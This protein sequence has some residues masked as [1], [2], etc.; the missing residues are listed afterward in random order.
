ME[1]YGVKISQIVNC[2]GIADK[3]ALVMQIYADVHGR[4]MKISRSGA[5][6]RAR[7]GHRGGPS[8]RVRT[9]I[10]ASGA[11]ENDRSETRLFTSRIPRRTRFTRS[12]T[13][14]YKE[15][16]DAFGTKDWNG[17]LYGRNEKAD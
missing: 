12:F 6:L 1:E 16:H 3:S 10:Y 2:G 4:P 14:L 9:R 5:D 11:E 8:L 7:L 15:L 13:R 17:N